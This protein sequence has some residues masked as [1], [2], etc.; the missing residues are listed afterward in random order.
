VFYDR[1]GADRRDCRPAGR[2]LSHACGSGDDRAFD[3][4]G[5]GGAS[6]FSEPECASGLALETYKKSI[7]HQAVERRA[8]ISRREQKPFEN[9]QKSEIGGEESRKKS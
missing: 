2:D 7:E 3:R 8:Q 4:A 5:S 1:G 9:G 6:E